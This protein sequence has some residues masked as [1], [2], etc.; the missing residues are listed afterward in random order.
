MAVFT[1][2]DDAGNAVDEIVRRVPYLTVAYRMLLI[3]SITSSDSFTLFSARLNK[4][5]GLDIR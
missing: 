3:F 5:Q 2:D 1:L 4:P